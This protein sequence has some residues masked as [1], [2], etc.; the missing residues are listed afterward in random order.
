MNDMSRSTTP[1]AARILLGVFILWQLFFLLS[2]NLLSFLPKV[3]D[4]G[5]DKPSAEAVA[6]DWLHEKGRVAD[7]ERMLTGVTTRWAEVSGQPQ[8]WSLFAPNVTNVIP[9]VAVEFCWEEE[10][11]S[12]RSISRWLT[13]IAPGQIFQEA[14]LATS[15]WRKEAER[16]DIERRLK[17]WL[18][19]GEIQVPPP[20]AWRQHQDTAAVLL[21]ANE[22]KDVRHYLKLGRFRLRRYESNIDVS[23]ASPDKNPDAVV[24]SWRE[25]IEDRVRDHWRLMAAYMQWK[26]SRWSQKHSDLPEP[27]QVILWVRLYRVPLPEE[28]PSPW[29]WQGPEWHPVARWQLG[30]E[31]TPELLPVE[32]FNPVVERF[33]SLRRHNES[34]HE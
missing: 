26:L 34:E 12:A 15:A 10:P 33:E 14:I 2:S 30:A 9:F 19:T 28:A 29:N 7:A 5:Q 6:P 18:V 13:P 20:A 31:W 4:F 8:N 32:M 11:T 22:P 1:I 27:K 3:R 16:Q 21:S 24:D 17:E 25:N 23:L